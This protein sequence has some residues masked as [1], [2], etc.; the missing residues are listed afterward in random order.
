M[1]TTRTLLTLFGVLLALS[2]IAAVWRPRSTDDPRTPLVWVSDNSPA[3]QAQ[4]EAFNRLHP[5][6]RLRLDYGSRGTQKI[7]L[8]CTSGVGPDLFDYS[9]EEIGAFVEAGILWDITEVAEGLGLSPKN[10]WPGAERNYTH[11]GRQ[12]GYP[13]NTGVPIL[14]FNRN[15]F[16]L[17]EIDYPKQ[18]MTIGEFIALAKAFGEASQRKLPPGGQ[19]YPCA[20]M[21]W[22][23][24][25]SALRGEFFDPLGAPNLD[26]NPAL[27]QALELHHQFLFKYRLMPTTIEAR[28]M[29]GQ[30]GWGSGNINQFAAGRFGMFVGGHWTLIAFSR[31]YHQQIAELQRRGVHPEEISTPTERPL[32]LGAVLIPRFPGRQPGYPISSRVAGINVR[33]PRR[34][35]ALAFLQYLAGNTYSELLNQSCDSLPG[36]P[37]YA[38]AGVEA[39]PPALDRVAMQAVT[40]EAMRYGYSFRESPFL[41]LAD[42]HRAISAQIDRMEADPDLPVPGLLRHAQKELERIM[43]RNLDRNPALK[44]RYIETFGTSAY[45]SLP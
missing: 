8:Q 24:L 14:I 18:L 26:N 12:Y 13:C 3:R 45:H 2:V 34:E 40:M 31:T 44:A 32:H 36:N 25:F 27:L 15:L 19:V 41:Q 9:S 39:G 7:I 4:I 37:G 33:S 6:L 17:L 35:E 30:G 23:I 28:T 21:D 38:D 20:G 29:S 11:Q 10:G 16:D 22:K 5:E 42:V 43:R 1:S